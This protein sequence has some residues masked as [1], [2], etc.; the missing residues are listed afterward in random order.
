MALARLRSSARIF[1]LLL[2][3]SFVGL[4]HSAADDACL[5]ALVQAHD[6][7]KHVV[8][9]PDA[10]PRD[11]CAVCH[12]VRTP[13]RPFAP[14]ALLQRPAVAGA[15]VDSLQAASRRDPS[16]GQLPARAPPASLI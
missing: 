6:E 11:H 10:G 8:G 4:W 14:P 12:S 15:V 16:L 2:L 5:T 9:A 1:A 13:R 3:G 7:S